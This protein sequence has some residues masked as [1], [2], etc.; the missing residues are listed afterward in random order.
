LGIGNEIA[1]NG[2]KKKKTPQSD[3]FEALGEREFRSLVQTNE[4]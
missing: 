2:R 1:K 3:N 4:Y